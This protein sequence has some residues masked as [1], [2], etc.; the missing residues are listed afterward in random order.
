MARFTEVG[1][2]D[3]ASARPSRNSAAFPGVVGP[4]KGKEPAAPR[5]IDIAAIRMIALRHNFRNAI[6]KFILVCASGSF[7]K[8][9]TTDKH[10]LLGQPPQGARFRGRGDGEGRARYRE[11]PGKSTVARQF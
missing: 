11:R 3:G 8:I 7:S 1:A 9:G 2:F 6:L 10:N 5:L 4:D